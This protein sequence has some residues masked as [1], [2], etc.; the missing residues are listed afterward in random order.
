MKYKKHKVITQR[1]SS[2]SVSVSKQCCIIFCACV[3][4][5]HPLSLWH[6]LSPGKPLAHGSYWKLASA[7]Q[8]LP[9]ERGEATLSIGGWLSYHVVFDLFVYFQLS[10]VESP[11]CRLNVTKSLV[12]MTLM[13]AGFIATREPCAAS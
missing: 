6:P 9:C 3:A 7:Q 11:G 12:A 1:F 13:A 2:M 8:S 10:S 5:H 4:S